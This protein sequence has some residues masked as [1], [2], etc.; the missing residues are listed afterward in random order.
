MGCG[1]KE[2]ALLGQQQSSQELCR[3]KIAPLSIND[4]RLG[5]MMM[6]HPIDDHKSVEMASFLQYA[7]GSLL[8]ANATDGTTKDRGGCDLTLKTSAMC[9]LFE[10]C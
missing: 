10:E 9:F 2:V 5:A 1:R 6:W 8:W 7:A 4:Y 3:H